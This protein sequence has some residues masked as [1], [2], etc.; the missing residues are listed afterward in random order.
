[1]CSTEYVLIVYVYIISFD[2][3]GEQS[4]EYVQEMYNNINVPIYT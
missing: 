3:N 2:Y 1:M 4:T